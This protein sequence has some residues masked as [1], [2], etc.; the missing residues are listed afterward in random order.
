MTESYEFKYHCWANLQQRE[1][2]PSIEELPAGD[3]IA[4]LY[5]DMPVTSDD[6]FSTGQL[7]DQVEYKVFA[8]VDHEEGDRTTPSSTDITIDDVEVLEINY[9]PAAAQ[10]PETI[11]AAVNWFWEHEENN[12]M[13]KAYSSWYY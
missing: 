3:E 2:L 13:D 5:K 11:L 8:T 10:S 1:E 7:D 6:T 12:A 4:G 9:E